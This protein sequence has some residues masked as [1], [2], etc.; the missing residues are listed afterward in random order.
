[1][2]VPDDRPAAMSS[3]EGAP[4]MATGNQRYN[5]LAEQSPQWALMTLGVAA[6]A[7]ELLPE[8]RDYVLADLLLEV[9]Q[10]AFRITS[11]AAAMDLINGTIAQAMRSV[12]L[13]GATE[14]LADAASIPSP[15]ST[16]VTAEAPAAREKAKRGAVGRGRALGEGQRSQQRRRREGFAEDAEKTFKRFSFCVFC[17]TS[18]SSAFRQS[19]FLF[20]PWH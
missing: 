13:A 10:K 20:P 2:R 11:E 3:A 17:E 4:R 16:Q 1:M 7:P 19:D 5:W 8:I 9:K 6:A 12:G 18:A 15:R 14:P